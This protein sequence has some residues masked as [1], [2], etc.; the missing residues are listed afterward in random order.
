[1]N[2]LIESNKLRNISALLLS[3]GWAPQLATGNSVEHV[4]YLFWVIGNS[5]LFSDVWHVIVAFNLIA[6]TQSS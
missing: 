6:D 1:M 2:D 4:S 3:V 5:D